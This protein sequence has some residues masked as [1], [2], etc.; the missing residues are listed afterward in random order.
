MP[1]K[2]QLLWEVVVGWVSDQ[3]EEGLGRRY[4]H[5]VPLA[6]TIFMLVLTANWIETGPGLLAQHRLPAGAQ[7]LTST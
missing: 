3:V 7:S 4:R 6:V 5:V 1:N 2:V